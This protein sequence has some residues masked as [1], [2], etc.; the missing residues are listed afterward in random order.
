[1]PT[2]HCGRSHLNENDTAIAVLF[3]LVSRQMKIHD[4]T[5]LVADC[6]QTL[7]TLIGQ[8][9][10]KLTNDAESDIN[11]IFCVLPNFT[12]NRVFEL[13]TCCGLKRN[14]KKY[15]LRKGQRANILYF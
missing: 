15:K 10:P 3:Y 2:F 14:L 6:V 9:I 11:V 8:I 1:M 12:L 4:E 13:C 5:R 7:R